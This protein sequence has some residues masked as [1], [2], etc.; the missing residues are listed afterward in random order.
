MEEERK[1]I[2]YQDFQKKLNDTSFLKDVRT[3]LIFV[4]VIF[5][6]ILYFGLFGSFTLKMLLNWQ[7]GSLAIM[8]IALVTLVRFDTRDRAFDDE[9]K[10]NKELNNVESE[11]VVET[12]KITDHIKGRAFVKKYNQDERVQSNQEK[13]DERIEKLKQKITL[14]E[15]K[16]KF[17]KKYELVKKEIANLEIH[18]L[19]DKKFKPIKYDEL[20]SLDSKKKKRKISAKEKL[21]YNPKKENFVKSVTNI[22][23]KGFG[24]GGAGSLPFMIGADLKTILAFYFAMFMAILMTVIQTYIKTRKKTSTR[25]KETRTFK[26]SLLKECNSFIESEQK[27]EL[28]DKKIT[29]L[30]ETVKVQE[31]NKKDLTKETNTFELPNLSVS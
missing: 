12:K 2:T 25:Y 19:V 1:K 7:L 4:I 28:E 5:V 6:P 22:V 9:I 15:I 16:G 23:L 11:I 13:T 17:G 26:L 18:K 27:K 10:S 20:Y 29:D 24:V 31:D 21:T 8:S 3:I 14:L 30:K